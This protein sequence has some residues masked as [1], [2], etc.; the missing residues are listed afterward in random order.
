MFPTTHRYITIMQ[1]CFMRPLDFT[2]AT[3]DAQT[4]VFALDSITFPA[5]TLNAKWDSLQN[6]TQFEEAKEILKR[7]KVLSEVVC[8]GMNTSICSQIALHIASSLD[9]GDEVRAV[10]GWGTVSDAP[11]VAFSLVGGEPLFSSD[12]DLHVCYM[13]SSGIF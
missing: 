4:K 7:L 3:H 6:F 5:N 10:L 12:T 8:L 1:W 11:S 13:S 2:A 9:C